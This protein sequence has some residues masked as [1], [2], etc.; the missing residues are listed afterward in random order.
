VDE[1]FILSKGWLAS[2]AHLEEV[3]L[4]DVAD[5]AIFVKIPSPPFYPKRL[6]KGQYDRRNVVPVPKFLRRAKKVRR[7]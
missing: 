2:F 6:F 7:G 5:D 1:A 3:V 4:Q